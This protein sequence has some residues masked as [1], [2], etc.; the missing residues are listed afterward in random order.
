MFVGWVRVIGGLRSV[1][2][3]ELESVGRGEVHFGELGEFC[4]S[5]G[6]AMFARWPLWVGVLSVVHWFILGEL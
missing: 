2:R 1:G 4:L 6:W 3:V 5:A